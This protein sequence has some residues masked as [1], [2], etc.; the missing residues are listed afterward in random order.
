[1]PMGAFSRALVARVL[2]KT[3]A[4][5]PGSETLPACRHW[6]GL[7]A[8]EWAHCSDVSEPWHRSLIDRM[9]SALWG[10]GI[11]GR[12]CGRARSHEMA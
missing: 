12:H 10:P 5:P 4:D 6:R 1:M 11:K 3:A 7:G 8:M 2:A 9:D